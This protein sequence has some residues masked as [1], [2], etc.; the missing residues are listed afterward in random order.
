M[1]V[2]HLI[3]RRLDAD[4]CITVG[5]QLAADLKKYQDSG[6]IVPAEINTPVQLVIQRTQELD[7]M[8]KDDAR[9]VEID[10]IMDRCVVS[11][12]DLHEA[13]AK[14]LS[15]AEL[16]PLD[17]DEQNFL[18]AS[19]KISSTSYPEGTEFIRLT[20]RRQWGQLQKVKKGLLSLSA[21][22]KLT[23]LT[24]LSNRLIRWIDLYGA[25]LGITEGSDDVTDRTAAAVESW[26]QALG[27][28]FYA[29]IGYGFNPAHTDA[30][31][32]STLLTTPYEQQAEVE[33]QEARNNRDKKKK[34][35]APTNTKSSA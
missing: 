28:L 18:A 19:Q 26:H 1:D 24:V 13:V 7:S 6:A 9:M 27:G 30:K 2:T 21:E 14:L 25:R 17:Q 12:N 22:L 32:L 3:P 34:K 11:W 20:F 29:L 35:E 15:G 4:S 5:T 16:L 31:T 23:G 8:S 10:R 33:R